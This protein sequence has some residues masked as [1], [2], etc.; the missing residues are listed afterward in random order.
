MADA[1]CVPCSWVVVN[2]LQ[3]LPH[4]SEGFSAEFQRDKCNSS[5]VQSTHLDNL[6]TL[7]LQADALNAINPVTCAGRDHQETDGI[8][9]AEIPFRF[10]DPLRCPC[11][12]SECLDL[13]PAPPAP[14]RISWLDWGSI[15]RRPAD[16]PARAVACVCRRLNA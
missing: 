7:P 16:A 9:I 11:Q 2:R 10:S 14:T 6:T 8:C 4:L 13:S 12:R 15:A 5:D 1:V 3:T